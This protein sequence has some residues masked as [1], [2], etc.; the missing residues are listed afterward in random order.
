MFRVY[1][2]FRDILTWLLG[3]I[4]IA[5]IGEFAIELAREHGFFEHPTA[6]VGAIL[7]LLTVVRE[8]PWFLPVLCFVGG[9]VIGMWLDSFVRRRAIPRTAPGAPQVHVPAPAVSAPVPVPVPDPPQKKV[10]VDVS[11]FYLIDLYKDKTT[12]LGDAAAAKYIG[13]WI[14]ATF[15]VYDVSEHMGTILV[16]SVLSS[17][18]G[19]MKYLAA[20]FISESSEHVS[21]I[22]KDTTITVRGEIFSIMSDR[23]TLQKCELVETSPS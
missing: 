20:R 7:G 6:T 1:K 14:K 2:V 4:L 12:V 5:L 17:E 21:L 16:Q 11:P 23:V 10:F 8:Q 9:L 15:K 19:S 13:K 18:L 22:A 3:G